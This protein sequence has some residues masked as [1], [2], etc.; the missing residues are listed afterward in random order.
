MTDIVLKDVDEV[1]AARI[2]RVADRHGWSLSRTLQHLLE[3]G[4]YHYDGD[5]RTGLDTSE[6]DV[7]QSAISALEGIPN[8]TFS[9][10]GKL[11]EKGEKGVGG[12]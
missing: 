7:L 6:A 10:I 9:N 8:D 2:R 5:G 1:L 3:Q 4:L 11:P 12:N